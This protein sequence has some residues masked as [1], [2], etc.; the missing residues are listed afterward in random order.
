MALTSS[1]SVRFKLCI[2]FRSQSLPRLMARAAP[3]ANDRIR[4]IRGRPRH[5]ERRRLSLSHKAEADFFVT[6]ALGAT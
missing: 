1:A 3:P 2:D 5:A 6:L 4:W